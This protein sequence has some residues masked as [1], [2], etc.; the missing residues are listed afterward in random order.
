MIFIGGNFWEL[1]ECPEF[2]YYSYQTVLFGSFNRKGNKGKNLLCNSG[3]EI[4][5]QYEHW[6]KRTS[7]TAVVF[8]SA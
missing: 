8:E 4:Q 5:G 1:V 2:E 7:T 6:K 3:I